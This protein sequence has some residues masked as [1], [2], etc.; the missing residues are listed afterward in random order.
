MNSILQWMAE[1]GSN[2]SVFCT[3]DWMFWFSA[4]LLGGVALGI[5][6]LRAKNR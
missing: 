4:I 3:G 6:Y 5:C 1:L 2:F